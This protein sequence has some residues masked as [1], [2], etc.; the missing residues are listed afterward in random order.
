MIK[1]ARVKGLSYVSYKG[2]MVPQKI[3]P[4]SRD[5]KCNLK[6]NLKITD[7]VKEENWDYFY[8]LEKKKSQDTYLQTLVKVVPIKRRHKKSNV[9]EAIVNEDIDL[10]DPDTATTANVRKAH[11]YVYNLKVNGIFTRACRNIFLRVFGITD[12]IM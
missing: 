6:C 9:N 11:S 8:S 7:E 10:D 5:C 12:N 1:N 4:S 3:M 2:K